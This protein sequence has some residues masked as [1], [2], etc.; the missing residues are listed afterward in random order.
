MFSRPKTC[1]STL[2]WTS[3]SPTSVSATNSLPVVN[4]T[5]F[6]GARL[7]LRP[8]FSRCVVWEQKLPGKFF[9]FIPFVSFCPLLSGVFLLCYATVG[10]K[11]CVCIVSKCTCLLRINTSCSVKFHFRSAIDLWE[12]KQGS[13]LEPTLLR[14]ERYCQPMHSASAKR[15][16]GRSRCN[17]L[18]LRVLL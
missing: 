4:W 16:V 11:F 6:A 10:L 8:S 14:R 15:L 12:S 3:R 18:F 13:C 5:R 2:I 9:C 7:T 17:P 1:C